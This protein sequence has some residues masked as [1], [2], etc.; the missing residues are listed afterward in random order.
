MKKVVLL[1]G[2]H[3]TGTSSV[4]RTCAANL[5][6]LAAAGYSYPRYSKR[7]A[8]GRISHDD[9]QSALLTRLFRSERLGVFKAGEFKQSHSRF[10]MNQLKLRGEFERVL[11]QEDR[12]VILV[13]EE[14]SRFSVEELGT[15]RDF[16]GRM[17]FVV[18][19][20]VCIRRPVAW[21]NS[22]V[23]QFVAGERSMRLAIADAVQSLA[24]GAQLI[25]P[26]VKRLQTVFPD[27]HFYSFDAAAR[28]P[29]GPFGY[30]FERAQLRFALRSEPVMANERKSDHAVRIH[31]LLNARLGPRFHSRRNE[32]FYRTLSARFPA[33]DR[34]PGDKFFLREHEIAPLTALLAAENEWLANRFGEGFCELSMV[35]R[36]DPVRLLPAQEAFLAHELLPA[37]PRDDME[38][39]VH[40]AV[41]DYIRQHKQRLEDK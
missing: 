1:A 41:E 36:D 30:F 39:A 10:K 40:Q 20:F 16:F 13:A 9:N 28:H 15:L 37:S 27:A 2:L 6:A 25:V 32:D 31:S 34:L 3:K 8:D 23:S 18:E 11:R 4:Q 21:V 29:S 19:V 33:I 22:L 14:C 12:D 17:G 24:A 26:C 5:P 35:F 7:S 38:H